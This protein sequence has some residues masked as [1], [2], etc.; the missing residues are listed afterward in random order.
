MIIYQNL[1]MYTLTLIETHRKRA[2]MKRLHNDHQYL[3][4]N[5][6]NLLYTGFSILICL[7]ML[8][9]AGCASD[10][11]IRQPIPLTNFTPRITI[12]PVWSVNIGASDNYPLE[13]TSSGKHVIASSANGQ[14]T[15]VDA[16]TGRIQWKI[17]IDEGFSSG[18]GTNG[19]IIAVATTKGQVLTFDNNGKALWQ[20]DIIGEALT[21][22]LVTEKLVLVRTLD[23]RIYAFDVTTGKQRWLY[24][25]APSPL[26]LRAPLGMVASEN[27]VIAGFPGGKLGLISLE[28]GAILWEGSLALAKGVSEIERLVDITGRPAVRD[29]YLCAAA[30]QGR[31]GCFDL[32]NGNLIWSAEFSGT[33]GVVMDQQ[34]VYAIDNKSI[35][36]GFNP[37]TGQALWSNKQLQ[38]RDL[39]IPKLIGSA[40][41][42]GD[43]KGELYFISI[44]DGTLLANLKTDGSSIAAAP[45]VV[46]DNLIVQTKDGRLYAFSQ[47]Q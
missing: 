36:N 7:G 30:F 19:N 47:P 5:T 14:L 25:R 4:E 16:V 27:T 38:W 46:G 41:V 15:Q 22:P 23:N 44:K 1:K 20:Q 34:A 13:P 29:R 11:H 18:P 21:T 35:I 28:N 2:M 26:V 40:L 32:A 9:L 3:Q 42:F 39:G 12:K 43:T 31:V 6:P 17:K 24:Q 10:A 33:T 45:V 37:Q 8:L